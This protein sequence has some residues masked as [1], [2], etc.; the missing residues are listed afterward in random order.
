MTVDNSNKISGLV[1]TFNE[2]KNIAAVI[3][4]LDFVDEIIILDSYSTDNTKEIA[5]SYK[6]VKFVENVFENFTKQRNLALDLAK[7]NWILF[8]DADERLS[9]EL[10]QEICTALLQEKKYSGYLFPRKFMFKNK[11]LRFSGK[12]NDRIFRLFDKRNAR[13]TSERLVHEKLDVNGEI[14]FLKNKLIHYSYYDYNVYKSKMES[15]GKL[16]A[17]EKFYK[18]ANITFLH[19]Y[20]HPVYNFLYNFIIRFG[21]L[22][23]KK[24]VIICY[25]N[26]YSIHARYKQLDILNS[27]K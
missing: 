4:D 25:L 14:G 22:D 23:G 2:E 18:K 15:Y 13:Y 8:I 21:F 10:K 26:A 12:Q 3:E 17:L 1:I 20:L 7:N 6:K 9:T 11:V 19:P 16:K 5:K 27:K 24:G